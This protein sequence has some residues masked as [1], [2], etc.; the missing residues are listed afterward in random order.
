LDQREALILVGVSGFSC[1]QAAEICGCPI[2]TAK[3]RVSRARARLAAIISLENVKDF[4]RNEPALP[5]SAA[6]DLAHAW[7]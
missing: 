6:N 4:D 1:M 2:G 7:N 5:T 3:S